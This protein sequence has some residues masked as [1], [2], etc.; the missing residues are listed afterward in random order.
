M[1]LKII[2]HR[3][4]SDRYPENTI[5]AFRKAIEADVD[6]IETDLR[7]SLDGEII[8]FHDDDLSRLTENNL[9][10]EVLTVKSLKKCDLGKGEPIPILDELITLAN[11]KVTLILEIKFHPKTYKKLCEILIKRIADKHDWIE[12]SCFDDRALLYLHHLD[13]D[14]RLHKLIKDRSVLQEHDLEAKYAYVSY[15]DIHVSL[16]KMALERGLIEK[17][18]IILWTVDKEDISEEKNAGLYGIMVNNISQFIK[19]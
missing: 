17:Y 13:P 6:G 18:K 4:F 1:D 14:I 12:V 10:V 7:L 5:L 3:G 11:G 9:K 19:E 2:A 16:S 8:L 15:F